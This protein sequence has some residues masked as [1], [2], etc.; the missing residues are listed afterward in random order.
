MLVASAA[1]LY[2]VTTFRKSKTWSAVFA[3]GLIAWLVL[4]ATLYVVY[5]IL[6]AH[7]ATFGVMCVVVAHKTRGLMKER[8]RDPEKRRRLRVLARA[9]TGMLVYLDKM[10]RVLTCSVSGFGGFGIWLI[11]N[12]ACSHLRGA[13]NAVGLPWGFLLE[14]HGWYETQ[15]V[16]ALV[17]LR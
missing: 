9:G 1:P 13:R 15:C 6:I 3:C 12:L 11:D 17:A 16:W 5:D 7:Q 8:V 14:L 2:R 10:H 4:V